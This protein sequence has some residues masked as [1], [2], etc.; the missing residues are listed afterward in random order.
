MRRRTFLASG[1]AVGAA[2]VAG[3]SAEEVD[4]GTGGTTGSVEDDDTIVVASTEAFVDAPSDSAGPWVKD[5]FEAR[6]GATLEWDVRDQGINYYI[7]RH[8]EGVGNDAEVY[9]NVRPHDLVRIDENA[10]GD[11][12]V[13][14]DDGALSN[15]DDVGEDYYFDPQDR[16]VPTW[17][18][19]C[20][21]VY[22]GRSLEAPGSF[23]DLLSEE[24]RG[25]LALSNPQEGTTGLL[26]ML[27]TI[28]EFGEDG[29]LEFW[30]DLLE[31]DARVLDGWSDVYPQFLEEE[32][33]MIVSYSN[34]RVYAKRDEQDL[35]K[36]QV[37]FLEGQ[38]YANL[39]GAARFADGTNDDLAHEFVDFV[40]EPD[41]QAAVAERNVTGPVVES[42]E[43]PEVYRDYAE[44]PDEIVFFDYDEL[45][46]NLSTW[47]ED[48][49]R[50]VAGD[51]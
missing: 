7:E 12:F 36:H 43:P 28:D 47:L 38:G 15:L 29:Y 17:L 31:N 48:W 34:D 37:G 51:V 4:D 46:G 33:P 6:T 42:A 8:N 30:N 27:W 16:V 23:E 21:L 44:H 24:Y 22:D 11:L 35:E 19:Y 5:E 10:D 9:L 45:S 3:C 49:G 40:L 32:V 14:I 41:V 18:S 50:E 20:S 1:A 25:K 39:L 2:A 26:F 13:P